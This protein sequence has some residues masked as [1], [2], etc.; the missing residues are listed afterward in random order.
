MKKN[1]KKNEAITLISLV[2][3]II[4][5][6]IL[7]GVSINLILGDNGI[8]QKAKQ[9]KEEYK[10]ATYFEDVNLEI[11]TEQTE[12]ATSPKEDI[13]IESI[14]TRVETKNWV[15]DV[16]M[17]DENFVEQSDIINNNLLIISTKDGYEIIVNV[18]NTNQTGSIRD[19][20]EKIGKTYTIKYDSN[21]GEGSIDS[22]EIRAG[23]SVILKENT[24]TKTDYHFVGWSEQNVSSGTTYSAG[25]K[26]KPEKDVTLYAIWSKD[27]VTISF[28]ANSA[29]GTM[30][31]LNI[32]KNTETKL[33]ENQYI[34]EGFNFASWNTLQ[35][36]TGISYENGANIT[37]GQNTTL[38]A[39]WEENVT[40]TM[41]VSNN[42]MTE[43]TT[44]EVGATA[45]G[46]SIQ[47]VELKLGDIVIYTKNVNN[48]TY[49][50]TLSLDNL[51]NLKDLEFYN[52]YTLNLKVT[53]TT[54]KIK[55]ASQEG[56]KNYTIGTAANLK[57]LAT[58]TNAGNPFSG[59]TILQIAD[60]DLSS[61]C[62]KVDGTT[63]NDVS[64][65]PIGTTS[66]MFKGTYNGN[67]MEVQKL[68]INTT[69]NN[70]GLFGYTLNATI[71]RIIIDVNTQITGNDQV[72]G[73]VG[74]TSASNILEC[75]NNGSVN[76]VKYVGGIVGNSY[77]NSEIS[78]C[79]N[80]GPVFASLR[81]A[82]GIAGLIGNYNASREVHTRIIN[83]YNTGSITS[84][85]YVGGI[86]GGNNDY[87]DISRCYNKGEI[88]G[89]NFESDNA[90]IGGISGRN[91]VKNETEYCYNIGTVNYTGEKKFV[92]GIIGWNDDCVEVNNCYNN[93]NVYSNG[94]FV[95]GIVGQNDENCSVNNCYVY[96]GNEIKYNGTN[97]T[98]AIGDSATNYSGKIMG[99]N[100]STDT[101]EENNKVL[102][103]MPTVY[104]VVNGLSDEEGQYWKKDNNNLNSPIL[105]WEEK[106]V[107]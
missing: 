100:E 74:G 36:G 94:S 106:Q 53:S 33:P 78:C 46:S 1:L 24:F 21:G 32:E 20:F 103:S 27:I 11:I 97:A 95:G 38:Y 63:E 4:V 92:G 61:V 82:G 6:I 102:T 70:Q 62:Y 22:Q 65:T 16:L 3:T 40:A 26:Y 50:E 69:A 58:L 45:L 51:S 72:G 13:F 67:Y 19:S 71:Q 64:W 86:T 9:A 80:K 81:C 15:K 55:E 8:I 68:Y 89:S 99:Y 88:S 56:V 44:I 23:F 83:C 37:I 47:K 2:V 31:T 34:K 18:D 28:D 79:A 48:K 96:S 59:E 12:R 66:D 91:R 101:A 76:G 105:K 107:L 60:I 90:F 43:G 84:L 49:T 98:K 104:Y 39:I 5:L 73:I 85:Y 75:K 14:K 30:E 7:A 41:Q 42:K 54:N 29:Q 17:C 10:K 25:S 77:T 57:K 35:D 87:G 93:A 52:D